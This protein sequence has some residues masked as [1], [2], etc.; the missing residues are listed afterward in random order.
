MHISSLCERFLALSTTEELNA[1]AICGM[2]KRASEVVRNVAKKLFTQ[3][4]GETSPTIEE[5][6]LQCPVCREDILL[7]DFYMKWLCDVLCST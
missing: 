1:P 4:F 3:R 5:S 6:G 7:Y 2:L